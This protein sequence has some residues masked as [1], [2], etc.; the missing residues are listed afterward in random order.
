MWKTGSGSY[1]RYDINRA[2]DTLWIYSG[3]SLYHRVR[4]RTWYDWSYPVDKMVPNWE[5][6]SWG[7]VNWGTDFDVSSITNQADGDS[8]H[9]C[10]Y[11]T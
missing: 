4:F 1:S 6:T 5:F 10:S 8:Y 9:W 7:R 3:E 2:N 11:G